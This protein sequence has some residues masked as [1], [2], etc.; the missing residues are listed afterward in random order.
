M[1]SKITGKGMEQRFTETVAAFK[2]VLC[3]HTYGI[4]TKELIRGIGMVEMR[5][6]R[7]AARLRL[8]DHKHD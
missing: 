8:S 5:F 1:L 2:S 7:R 6:F 3:V 4:L